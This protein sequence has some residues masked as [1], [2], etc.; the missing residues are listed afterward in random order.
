MNFADAA[1]QV[2]KESGTSLPVAEIT[3]RALQ[4]GLIRPRSDD[5]VTYVRAAIRKD[6]RR[7]ESRNKPARFVTVSPGV[8]RLS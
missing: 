3:K 4:Q 6:N 5:P 2:L 1:A 8:Y 7:Q